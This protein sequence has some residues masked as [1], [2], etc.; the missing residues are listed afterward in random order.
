LQ[1]VLA[2]EKTWNQISQ[3]I[4]LDTGVGEMG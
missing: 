2:I 1:I 4:T 3:L